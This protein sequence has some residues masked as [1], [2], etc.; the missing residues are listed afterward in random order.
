MRYR[1][2]F[3]AFVAMVLMGASPFGIGLDGRSTDPLADSAAANVFLFVRT[4]CPITNR[5]APELARIAREFESRGARFWLIYDDRSE[6]VDSIRQHVA[7]YRFPGTPLRDPNHQLAALAHAK[8]APESAVF[9][10]A[11]QLI[12]HG[13]IDD[14]YVDFGKARA[15]ADTHD[16]EDAIRA[17][18]EHKPV[19]QPETRAVGC[20]LADIE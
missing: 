1:F 11:G 9:D 10:S 6:S 18:L 2:L 20:A 4:D 12:Y 8:V 14:R 16:L 3:V 19:P 17:V 15:A 7:E 13:R 5:Y